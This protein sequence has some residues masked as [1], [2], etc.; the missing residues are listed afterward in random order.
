MNS[1]DLVEHIER[2]HDFS[3]RT[4]G[5]GAR[6][7]GLIDHITKEL[8]EIERDPLD[9]MEWIDVIMLGLDGAWRSGHA[10]QQIVRALH[11]KLERNEERVWPDWRTADPDKAIEHVRT[12]EKTYHADPNDHDAVAN[13][14][15][16]KYRDQP[17]IITLPPAQF[18]P[19]RPELLAFAIR[20]ERRLSEQD[21]WHDKSPIALLGQ[22][23]NQ[24]GNLESLILSDAQPADYLQ[25]A[26]DLAVDCLMIASLAK[27]DD[28]SPEDSGPGWFGIDQ[29]PVWQRNNEATYHTLLLVSGHNVSLDAVASWSD[30]QCQQ[31]EQWALAIHLQASDNDGVEVPRTPE[32]VR[33]FLV[34]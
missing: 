2:Q 4:F 23:S 27:V 22:A 5:P 29:A 21:R 8:R 10:P 19:L 12:G 32:C 11:D 24:A 30:E 34:R 3:L 9:L 16:E 1:Y 14:L 17:V 18:Y 7:K 26:V 25:H 15:L 6:T 31:A 33:P 20:M 13:A 28:A